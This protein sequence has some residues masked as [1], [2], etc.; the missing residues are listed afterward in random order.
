[1]S[2]VNEEAGY[3]P[4]TLINMQNLNIYINQVQ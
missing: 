4:A 3:V 2:L 1:M